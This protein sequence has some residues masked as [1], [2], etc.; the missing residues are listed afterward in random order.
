MLNFHTIGGEVMP[1]RFAIG[2]DS[3]AFEKDPALQYSKPLI[4]G[5]TVFEGQPCLSANSDGDVV[6]HALTNAVSGITC[7]NILGGLADEMCGKG[8]TDSSEYLQAALRD[9]DRLGGRITAVSIS[10]EAKKPK[11]FARI[12]EMREH[13]GALIGIDPGRCGI[14]A[15][16]GEGLTAFG[17]GEGI[18]V[19]AAVTV[20]FDD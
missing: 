3:H 20:D 5:G 2:Q 4:L 11:L 18:A 8:I 6:L 1:Q 12:P 15:T 19:F 16:S 13:I 17:K 10:I 9:L 14:T 7:I